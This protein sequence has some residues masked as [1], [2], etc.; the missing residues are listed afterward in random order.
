MCLKASFPPGVVNIVPGHGATAGAAVASH[1]QVDKVAFTGSTEVG[2]Q[3]MT[4]CGEHGLKRLSLEL[5]GKSPNIIF[6]DADI[7][8][9]IHQA[10]A[11][12]FFNQGQVCT[13]GSRV[14][15]EAPIYDKFVERSVE[16]AKMRIMGDPFEPTTQ[17]GPQID[18]THKE[19]I[20]SFIEKGKQDGARLLC[21]GSPWG[22]KGYFIEPTVFADVVD[23]MIIAQEEIFGPVMQIMRFDT[24]KDLVEKANNTIYGL[25][26][27]VF[28]K[29]IDK[30]LYVANNIQAGTV[31]VNCYNVFDAAAPFGGYKMSGFG[32]E[33][34]QYGLDSYT[35]VKS[36]SRPS[37]DENRRDRLDGN[38][39]GSSMKDRIS[40][41]LRHSLEPVYLEVVNDSPLHDVPA[42]SETHF[43]LT[44]VSEKFEGLSMVQR[45]RLVNNAILAEFDRTLHALSI[46]TSTPQEWS[47]ISHKAVPCHR[48]IARADSP[49]ALKSFVVDH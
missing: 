38:N 11:G 45:H 9:A 42:Q 3:I 20:L 47:G 5:G 13:A 49:S 44:V 48:S 21:G 39:A 1:R 30:A 29:D 10:H 32:R 37:V 18:K 4:S 28:T 17:Q 36:V 25:A 19:R 40:A 34:G 14:F 31:W 41:A 26:A 35:E 15:V 46:S 8:E 7:D 43:R 33:L 2:K 6:A 22:D 16:L 12:L 23:P 27:G 24:M